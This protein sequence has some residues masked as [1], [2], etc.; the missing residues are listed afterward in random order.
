MDVFKVCLKPTNFPSFNLRGNEVYDILDIPIYVYQIRVG[1][2]L[3]TL[4]Y[5]IR[6]ISMDNETIHRIT[7]KGNNYKKNTKYRITMM[8]SE[9]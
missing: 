3:P 1:G 5:Y 6:Q 9:H 2:E 8:S 4:S 7:L